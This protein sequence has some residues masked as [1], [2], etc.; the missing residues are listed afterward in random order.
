MKILSSERYNQ[1]RERKLLA[2]SRAESHLK[3]MNVLV[4]EENNP[5][6][7]E[8]YIKGKLEA[9]R[10]LMERKVDYNKFLQECITK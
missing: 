7:K 6:L 4:E 3:R 1:A 2:I 5:H 9:E 10:D 8:G